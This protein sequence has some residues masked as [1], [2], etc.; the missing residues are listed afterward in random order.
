MADLEALPSTVRGEIIEGT[1]YTFPRPRPRH[2]RVMI[3]LGSALLGPFQKGR[4]GPGGWWILVVPGIDHPGSP[5]Y[6][7]DLAGW[8]RERLPVLPD[9]PLS[10]VPDWVCEILSPSTRG[11]DQRIKRPF[12]ARI[13][14]A[15]LWYI[16]VEAR[17]LTVDELVS[18]RWTEL[19][20]FGDDDRFRTAPFDAVEFSLGELWDTAAPP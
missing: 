19:A 1:L 6:S 2:Q 11:Y 17:T 16:D 9:G 8:R 20:V 7:P 3:E 12:Y 10:V 18:G 5:E 13:G 4:G 14:V 15:H